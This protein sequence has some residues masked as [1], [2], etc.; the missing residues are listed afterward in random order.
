MEQHGVLQAQLD[1]GVHTF[2][3]RGDD[4]PGV[5]SIGQPLGAHVAS[6]E[7]EPRRAIFFDEARAKDLCERAVPTTLPEIELPE[8]IA[9]G[10]ESLSE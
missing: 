7:K 9:R 2:D 6:K 1:I 10:N 3:E 5:R 8:S 4:L